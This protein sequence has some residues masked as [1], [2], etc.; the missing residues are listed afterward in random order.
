MPF[1]QSAYKPISA[2]RPKPKAVPTQSVSPGPDHQ[3]VVEIA[4]QWPRNAA[5]LILSKTKQQVSR[6]S[7]PSADNKNA[8]RSLVK[9]S[10]LVD[11]PKSLFIEIPC[12]DDPTPIIIPLTKEVNPVEKGT[13]RDEWDN[14]LVPIVP[15]YKQGD[16]YKAY[17]SGNIYVIWNKQLWRELEI[18]P[19]GYFCDLDVTHQH[20]PAKPTRHV[21]IDGHLLF[22]GEN[23]SF[24]RYNL[25]QAG[26]VVYSGE[27]DLNQQ[28]CVFNLVE[29]QVEIEFID[30]EHEPLSLAT[31]PSP[32]KHQ[33]NKDSAVRGFPLANIWVP[34][35]IQGEVQTDCYLYY[36]PLPLS[37]DQVAH[38]EA[39]CEKMGVSLTE[40][41][42]Y[43][44]Q[45]A[46][47]G[48]SVLPLPELA[49]DQPRAAMINGQVD[50][51][52][53][54]ALLGSAG[55]QIVL[56]YQV[57]PNVDQS[58]DFFMLVNNEHEWSQK[59]YFR[60][61]VIDDEG[62]VHL[63]FSGWPAEVEQVD[64]V[65][66]SHPAIGGESIQLITLKQNI[67]ISDLLG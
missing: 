28:A 9:F 20:A 39:N 50:C 22:P 17:E 42:S 35:R 49:E 8:H 60:S 58:D 65:R 67:H 37:D 5:R 45:Q 52:V 24:E 62:F 46:F 27:L 1:V 19:N 34:Y 7:V 33:A 51:N 15:L 4:G 36:S 18:N 16:E 57:C 63:R 31:L 54:A 38:L 61:S 14:V 53:A 66:G 12:V 13:E 41:Q 23:I 10:G 6:L 64:I 25:I 48:E 26:A 43:S 32:L 55:N 59:A 11:E 56:R 44:D 40:L 21:N 3:I 2:D 29:E 30:F 47:A